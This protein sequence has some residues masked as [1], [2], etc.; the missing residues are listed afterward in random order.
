M[1]DPDF[2]FHKADLAE[3][4]NDV[5][6]NLS[7]S[8]VVTKATI[9]EMDQVQ[10]KKTQDTLEFLNKQLDATNSAL[11]KVRQEL[12]ANADSTIDYIGAVNQASELK[13]QNGIQKYIEEGADEGAEAGDKDGGQ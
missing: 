4:S 3:I 7:E 13:M 11:I 2:Y 10:K 12:E 5:L 1:T 9:Q 6:E 8:E